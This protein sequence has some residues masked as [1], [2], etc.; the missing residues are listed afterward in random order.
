MKLA[1]LIDAILA[2]KDEQQAIGMRAYMR[3]QFQFLGVS[4]PVRRKICKPYFKQAKKSQAVD[5]DFIDTCW[6]NPYREL[7]YIAKDYLV[8]MQD[9]LT[10][11]EI[12]KIRELAV[13]KSW[14]DTIDGL[15]RTVGDIVHSYPGMSGL[16]LQWSTD[17][18]FWLRRIAIDH[19]LSRKMKTDPELLGKI[20]ENNF[21]SD[22]FF[23]NKAIGW[24]LRE[25]SKT[26]PQWVKAFI[27]KNNEKMAKLSIREASKYV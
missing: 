27:E 13:T 9:V 12:P 14:W 10:P 15:D 1:A 22:E 26:N 25:Y 23:I 4:T 3:D 16:M 11:S 20:I 8:V 19:Q 2:C 5:W 7:Q 24:A 17:E 6:A 18:N 21:G